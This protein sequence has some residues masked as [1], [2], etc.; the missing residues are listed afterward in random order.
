[1]NIHEGDVHET[2]KVTNNIQTENMR[3]KSKARLNKKK[4]YRGR[5]TFNRKDKSFSVLLINIR[6][7]RSNEVALNKVLKVV[8]PSMIAINETLL[9]GSM[10]VKLDSYQCWSKNR[11]NQGGG[12]IATGVSQ[13]YKDSSIGIGEGKFDDEYL[14]TRVET[15]YPALNV[16]N[17]Y[18]E[19]RKTSK[20]EVE[21]K[22]SR[23]QK[24]MEDIRARKEFC[25]LTGDLN[26]LVGN[27]ELGVPGN[28]AEISVG[29]Q[30]LRELLSTKN[31]TLVN[32]LG[33]DIVEGGPFTRI[34]P[35]T[36][37]KSCLDLFIVSKEL[38]P[39]ISKLFI[40]SK[41][42]LGL[43]RGV[44]DNGI[45]KMVYPDHFPALITFTNLPIRQKMKEE[46]LTKWNLAKNEG[47]KKYEEL[48]DKYSE[49][50]NDIVENEQL[51]IQVKYDKMTKIMEKIKFKAFGKVTLKN[52]QVIMSSN[53]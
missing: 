19:Q 31:W 12:G 52:K 11:E 8:N 1:M 45:C 26:K 53:N 44:K 23:L 22:W 42:K 21:L 3:N 50:L 29:G 7:F 10:K 47:W 51:S 38:K 18:G 40:D 17:C 14:I 30:L 43:A 46:K 49:K 32:G 48:T 6:G 16:I 9:S 5:G 33:E 28:H 35:A 2:N 39:Y 37:N 34:D 25:L 4:K 24:E 41:R 13:Q 20:E 15:F 36:G 27:D